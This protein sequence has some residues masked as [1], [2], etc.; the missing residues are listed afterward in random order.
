MK[1]RIILL[2][3]LFSG[4]FLNYA[5]FNPL[6]KDLKISKIIIYKSKHR[7]QVFH[8]KRLLKTYCISL[9]RQPVGAKHFRGDNKTPEGLYF[10]N[11][12]NPNSK[13]HLNLGISYPSKKDIAYAEKYGKS[14]GGNIKI[15]GI[16]NGFGFI[17]K[18][19]CLYDW[20]QG[21][22]AVTNSEIEEL[23]RS[24]PLGTPIEIK[25]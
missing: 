3:V 18:L 10:I 6:N 13:Y 16:K 2:V 4:I 17:G 12:K 9:G 25:K 22:I 5:H 21:C 7:M 1:K 23:Y 19:H 14:A 8:N 15:H 24:I 20:T 11:D